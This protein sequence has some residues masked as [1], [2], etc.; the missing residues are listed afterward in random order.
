VS[1]DGGLRA[2]AG[3][4]LGRMRGRSESVAPDED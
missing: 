4:A 1:P 3:S 2:P